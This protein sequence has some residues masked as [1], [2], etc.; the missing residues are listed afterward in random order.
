MYGI[1]TNNNIMII[2]VNVTKYV[3]LL[4]IFSPKRF[5][6]VFFIIFLNACPPSKGNNGKEL[7]IA[8]FMFMNQIQYNVF[9][10]G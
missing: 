5:P 2:I 7:K 9:A 8:R 3:I 4:D 10:K 1:N 6:I